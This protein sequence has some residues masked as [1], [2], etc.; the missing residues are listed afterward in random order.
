M[1]RIRTVKTMTAWSRKLQREEVRIGLV[2]TMGALHDGHRSLIRAARLACDAVA[3]SI[4]VNP[5]QF[6]PL[7]DF[8]RYPRVLVKD[9]RLCQ[10][11]GVDTV[12]IPRVQEMYP[13]DFE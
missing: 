1:Q 5:L 12:F 7:E 11:G 2:P 13:T 8:D 4:F 10:S 3:V 6:G 9:L